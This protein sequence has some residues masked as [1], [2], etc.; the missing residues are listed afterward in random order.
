MSNFSAQSSDTAASRKADVQNPSLNGNV[1]QD[2][3]LD[4]SPK[5]SFPELQMVLDGLDYS[6][7]DPK[8]GF[9]LMLHNLFSRS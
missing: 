9:S 2:E 8:S 6:E 3:D 4:S 1:G 7:S 5:P